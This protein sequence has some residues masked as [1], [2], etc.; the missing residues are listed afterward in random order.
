MG[1][2]L[3]GDWYLF[4]CSCLNVWVGGVDVGVEL[5]FS[6]SRLKLDINESTADIWSI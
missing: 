1:S 3:L 6:A 5:L 4:G 2:C